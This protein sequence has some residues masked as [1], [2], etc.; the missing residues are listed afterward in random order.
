MR[1]KLFVIAFAAACLSVVGCKAPKELVYLD[2]Q[3]VN[4]SFNGVT[5]PELAMDV[6]LFN[7]NHYGINVKDAD[8]DVF[9]N[10]AHIGK[11]FVISGNYKIPGIDTFLLPIHADVDWKNVLPNAVKLLFNNSIDLKV[12][13]K[14]RAGKHGIYIG[15]PVNYSGKQ[16]IR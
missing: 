1:S 16:P 14:I 11:M 3:H 7:P 8:I 10:D 2:M 9:V 4:L 6:K 12:K 5:G 15:V 13:G